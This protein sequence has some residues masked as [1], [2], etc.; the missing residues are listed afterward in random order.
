MNNYAEIGIYG[1]ATL[2][3]GGALY[4]LHL[5]LAAAPAPNTDLNPVGDAPDLT[6]VTTALQIE[7]QLTTDPFSSAAGGIGQYANDYL[8][9][10]ATSDTL[11]SNQDL[12]GTTAGTDTASA[13]H[14]T[15]GAATPIVPAGENIQNLTPGLLTPTIPA[16]TAT[17]PTTTTS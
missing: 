8:P 5:K 9:I 12:P 15:G 3:I 16:P 2:L 13:P 17:P 4:L 1:A 7:Q 10:N 14:E 11:F 6:P